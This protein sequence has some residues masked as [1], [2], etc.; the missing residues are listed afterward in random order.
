M[1]W[2][3]SCLQ[4]KDTY[5]DVYLYCNTNAAKLLIQDMEL[6]YSGFYETHENFCLPNENLWALPKI[7]TYSLQNEPFL[8]VDGDVFLFKKLPELLLNSELIAQNKEEATDYYLSSQ[9]ELMKCFTYFPDCVREDFSSSVPIKAVN[10]GIIGGNN[11]AFIREYSTSALE[12]VKRNIENYSSITVH[13]FN[14]FFEQHL[15]Y[16]LAAWK[17]MPISYLFPDIMRDNQYTG[18]SDFHEVPFKKSYCHLLGQYK[19]DEYTC[20]QMAAKLKQMYPEYYYRIIALCKKKNVSLAANIYACR[21]LDTVDDYMKFH[22]EAKSKYDS[23]V[24]KTKMENDVPG[25]N[26]FLSPIADKK[27]ALI[28]LK[29]IVSG[30]IEWDKQKDALQMKS[31]FEHFSGRLD[32]CLEKTGNFSDEYLYGRDIDSA[33]WYTSLFANEADFNEKSISRCCEIK[34][35][36]SQF[37]WAGIINKNKRVGVHYYEELKLEPGNFYNLFVPEV[38][39]AGFSLHDIDEMENIILDHLSCPLIV[40]EL[41]SQMHQYVDEDVL[42]NNLTEYYSLLTVL[43][44]QLVLKKAIKPF[45]K[46]FSKN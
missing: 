1:S 42:Q 35:V 22:Q 20:M 5:H 41:F 33:N 13:R 10:A 28:T 32:D 40:R 17:G 4:L 44:K 6:P 30:S 18:F 46:S 27:S 21:E 14:V 2:A 29:E 34:V 11:T 7:Y 39:D 31:D 15:F 38:F 24:L 3:L 12:Y 19:R 25:K 36:P 45:E 16:S 9:V 8:H 23:S 43:I 37:D 26:I